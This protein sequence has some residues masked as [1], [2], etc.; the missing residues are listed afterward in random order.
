MAIQSG[1]VLP[2]DFGLAGSLVPR[3]VGIRVRSRL[4]VEL[5]FVRVEF[6]RVVQLLGGE[7]ARELGAT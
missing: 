4:V 1:G 2:R 7:R 3:R 6:A 5:D